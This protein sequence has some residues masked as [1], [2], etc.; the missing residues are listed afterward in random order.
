MDNLLQAT[1]TPRPKG[2][3]DA[4]AAGYPASLATRSDRHLTHSGAGRKM[5][6]LPPESLIGIDRN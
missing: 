3:Q 4:T 6:G 5:I 1:V 2:R